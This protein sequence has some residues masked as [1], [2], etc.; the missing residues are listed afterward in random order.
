MICHRLRLE[1]GL[2]DKAILNSQDELQEWLDDA[3][4]KGWYCV[5]VKSERTGEVLVLVNHGDGYQLSRV[6]V[7]S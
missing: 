7:Q 5:Q 4:F 6:M 1:G 3:Q 2:S